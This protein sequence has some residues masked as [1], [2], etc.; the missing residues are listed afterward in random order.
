MLAVLILGGL[1]QERQKSSWLF[2][3]V[4]HLRHTDTSH[5]CSGDRAGGVTSSDKEY[6]TGE[7]FVRE[8]QMVAP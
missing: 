3:A 1:A 6:K 2:T 4:S 5:I 7:R 8:R